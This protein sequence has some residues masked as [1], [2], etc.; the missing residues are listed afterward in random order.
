MDRRRR[1]RVVSL[2]GVLIAL[3]VLLGPIAPVAAWQ[4]TPEATSAVSGA[5]DHPFI[6]F[7]ADGARQDLIDRYIEA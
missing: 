7:A 2:A 5:G 6:F 4:A 3:L 1:S